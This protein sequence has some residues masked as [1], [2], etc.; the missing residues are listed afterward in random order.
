MT[1]KAKRFLTDIFNAYTSD[2]GQLPRKY[3][4][5]INRE[6]EKLLSARQDP[7]P[8]DDAERQALRDRAARRIVCDYVAGMTDRYAQETYLTLFMPGERV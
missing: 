4:E 6:E 2:V 3:Q 8:P 5:S 7:S 1:V